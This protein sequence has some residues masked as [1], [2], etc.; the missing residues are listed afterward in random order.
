MR[1]AV[2]IASVVSL[3][4][5]PRMASATTITTVFL[6][7]FVAFSGDEATHFGSFP[8]ALDVDGRDVRMNGLSSGFRLAFDRAA[9][10]KGF[11]TDAAGRITGTEYY[12]TAGDLFLD[13]TLDTG[14]RGSMH[15][16]LISGDIFIPEEQPAV[17]RATD[18]IGT[19]AGHA[20]ECG[21]R[22]CFAFGPGLLDPALAT[23]LGLPPHITGGQMLT[24]FTAPDTPYT[25]PDRVVLDGSFM[26]LTVPEPQSLALFALGAV[27]ALWRRQRRLALRRS[28]PDGRAAAAT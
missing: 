17:P 19:P 9:L 4:L 21:E 14:V 5:V 16:P 8:I 25:D 23:A 28:E 2:L 3:L 11:Y 7:G 26:S 24:F 27:A 10:T 22:G 15:L 1:R 12:W 13:L 20:S 6:D 18:V